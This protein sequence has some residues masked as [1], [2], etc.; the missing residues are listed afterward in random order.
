MVREW[1]GF[2]PRAIKWAQA[3]FPMREGIKYTLSESNS[4]SYPP[5]RGWISITKMAASQ[6]WQFLEDNG[7]EPD[8]YDRS[9]GN[10]ENWLYEKRVIRR[11]K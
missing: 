9:L 4:L 3:T 11:K 7:I 8:T 6:Y 10:Y 1:K 5:K 2:P